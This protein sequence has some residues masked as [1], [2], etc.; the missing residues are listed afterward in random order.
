MANE[1]AF[2]LVKYFKEN[3]NYEFTTINDLLLQPFIQYEGTGA[4]ALFWIEIN[5]NKYLFKNVKPEENCWLGELLSKEFADI[6][7][8][9]CAEYVLCKLGN[10]YG[11]LSKKFT[12]QN[13]TIILG[14]QIVQETL[15]KYPYQ[16]NDNLLDDLDFLDLY[17][18]PDAILKFERKTKLKYLYNNLNNLEQ[19][20]SL[21]EIYLDL[22][23]KNKDNIKQIMDY[24]VNTFM[25]DLITMHADRHIENW[26]IVQNQDTGDLR[27]A[28]LFDNSTAF[29]LWDPEMNNRITNFYK[30]LNEYQRTNSPKSET[31]FINFM[32]KDR[33]LLTPS[34]D[35]IKNA[36]AR[37]RQNNLEILDYFLQASDSSYIELFMSY[38]EKIKNISIPSLLNKIEKEQ[39]VTIDENL[40]EYL[41]DLIIWNLH[42]LENR[43]KSYLMQ[44]GRGRNE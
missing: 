31:K 14:A 26:C 41:N 34:E 42:Y 19:L 43:V 23:N 3:Y 20:W 44:Q 9:P 15:D 36:K 10:E 32:Y 6:L 1:D 40:K 4:N 16:I 22:K 7:G 24:L 39:K 38:I 11:I 25:F 28:E 21:L 17:N 18:I 37:K 8:I 12:K 30:S 33:M 2:D 27:T 35:A 13:E 29:G 5:N